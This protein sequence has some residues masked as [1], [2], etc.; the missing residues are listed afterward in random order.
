MAIKCVS[1]FESAHG[2]YMPGDIVEGPGE[3]VQQLL[4]ES[5]LSF[6]VIERSEQEAAPAV[7]LLALADKAVKRASVRRKAE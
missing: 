7:G 4:R 6:E 1:K 3:L 5:P 2:K